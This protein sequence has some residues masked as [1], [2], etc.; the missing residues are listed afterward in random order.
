M[1]LQNW[2]IL[3]DEKNNGLQNGFPNRI[4]VEAKTAVVPGMAQVTYP[5]KQGVFWY[6]TEIGPCRLS[7]HQRAVLVFESVDYVAEVWLNGKKAGFHEGGETPFTFDVTEL[8]EA[9]NLLC[10]RVVKPSRTNSV[11]GLVFSEIPHSNMMDD[12]D[13]T[14]GNSL[15]IS[16]IKRHVL[17]K[18]VPDV[19]FTDIHCVADCR[20]GQLSVTGTILNAGAKTVEI[21]CI[22]AVEFQQ[23]GEK[24]GEG[25]KKVKAG[26][27]AVVDVRFRIPVSDMHLWELTDPCLYRVDLNLRTQYCED[28]ISCRTGFRELKVEHGYF[29]LNGKRIF[30]KS[31]HTGNHIPG[32]CTLT[33]AERDFLRRDLVLAKAE[34]FNMVRFI[35]GVAF[36]EQL[37]FCDELGLMVY[38]ENH[39]AWNLGV[40]DRAEE[41][42]DRELSE[43]VRRDRNHPCLTVWGLLNEEKQMP[44][45]HIARK[46]LKLLRKLDMTRLVLINSGRWD[47]D[48]HFGS[49][50]NPG[51]KEW[52]YVWGMERPDFPAY[53]PEQQNSWKWEWWERMGEVHPYPGFPISHDDCAMIRHRFGHTDKP[54]FLSET[55]IGSMFNVMRVCRN[56][57]A[58]GTDPEIFDYKY[59]RNME[60]MFLN[61]WTR[62][63]F[64]G[65]YPFPEDFLTASELQHSRQRRLFF[66]VI[67]SNPRLCGYNLTGMLDHALTGEGVWSLFREWKAGIAEVLADGFAPLRWCLF[68]DL[69]PFYE[70]DPVHLEA[71]L[72]NENILKPGTYQAQFRVF[73]AGQGVLW[74]KDVSFQIGTEGDGIDDPPLATPVLNETADL[75]LAPGE[76]I[77]AAELTHGGAA[78]SNRQTFRVVP[79]MPA[80]PDIEPVMAVAV[81]DI[82][83]A[84]FRH[85]GLTVKEFEPGRKNGLLI[86]G[87]GK[88]YSGEGNAA[89]WSQVRS[90]LESGGNVLACSHT[91][92]PG[93]DAGKTLGLKKTIKA[94][95]GFSME[96]D[97]LYHKESVLKQDPVFDGVAPAGLLDW[98]LASVM[99]RGVVWTGDDPDN[100]L[101]ASF[102]TGMLTLSGYISGIKLGEYHVGK[103]VLMMN[104]FNLPPNEPNHNLPPFE[105]KIPAA[106]R[107][108]INL[109]KKL[110]TKKS[111]GK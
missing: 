94:Q 39:A 102:G 72:A 85:I 9:E 31:T 91:A 78:C 76:Y 7:S 87:H 18:A 61:D 14:S 10:V 6:W 43:M 38:E 100:V 111:G 60:E 83:R 12:A 24:C 69:V 67:R 1:E 48:P 47:K 68:T 54:V 56:F 32:R 20:T 37:D 40:S 23:T 33:P 64:A 106:D 89:F 79:V 52:E 109:L 55:G 105:I 2:K 4:P 36:P 99:A 96:W 77:F 45:F 41:I 95:D 49:V 84:F 19:H 62:W 35:A 21:T 107:L 13:F 26:P 44:I 3:F 58:N 63:G 90:F 92:F 11:D 53:T 108:F 66:D 22:A 74:K 80:L 30:L 27:H 34:G 86:I 17:L 93:Y 42:F 81:N 98:E 50:S 15:N 16:G 71:V 82:D 51:S 25:K 29:Y 97:W 88:D 59:C 8:L 103:G 46:S 65:L 75:Q 5:G 104:A 57:E 70:G 28:R 110:G 73:A 101:A